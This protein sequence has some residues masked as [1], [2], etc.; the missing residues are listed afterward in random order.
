MKRQAFL[1]LTGLAAAAAVTFSS[2]KP[3]ETGSP[4][5]IG[6]PGGKTVVGFSQIGADNPWRTAETES[7]KSE[8]AKR[9][10]ELKFSDAQGQQEAQ[11]SAIR[12]FIAQSVSAIIL[13][14]KVET[15]WDAI[16]KEAKAAKI[17]VILVDRGVSVTDPSLFVTLI[18]SD[19]VAEGRMA[20]EWLAQ[21]TSGKA[22]IVQLEGTT[23]AAP[24]NDRKKGFEAAIAAHP[25]MKVLASQTGDFKRSDGK[26][27][28]EALIKA[29]GAAITAVYAHNDDMAIGAIQA[30]EAAGR[31][32]G[33]DVTVV[34]IDGMGF[35]FEA[36]KEGKLN[37]TVECN[38][39][40]GPMAFDV[41]AKVLRGEAV[42][43]QL[44]QED[45]LFDATNAP[46]ELP[47]RKY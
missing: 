29:H 2:C 5:A 14:P 6:T 36:I 33:K 44:V 45:R 35:A 30:L 13:A 32:P 1:R 21:Q 4:A 27:V 41:I 47:N 10:I 38:P 16:L 37:C 46:T 17:P 34:S 9:G 43:K 12:S 31:Q 8:A 24:A 28:M 26:N 20:G 19:F 3:S 22:G 40:L 18:A 15:G 39:L 11:I 42:P 23:G 7:I 25:D